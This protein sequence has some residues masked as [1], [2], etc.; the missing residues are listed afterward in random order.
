MKPNPQWRGDPL[1]LPEL[2]RYFGIKFKELPGWKNWGMGDF[3]IIQG[4]FWHHTGANNTPASYIARNTGLGGALSST[5]HTDPI[6]I[7]AI[8]GAGF[9]YHAGRGSG[10]GY[11]TNNAN[12]FSMGFEIQGDGIR[13]WNPAQLESVRRATAVILWFLG[14][15]ATLE[16]MTGH[17][18]YSM[19][20]QGKW[21]PG[22]GNG[23]AGAVMN[24]DHQR[25]LVNQLIDNINKYGQLDPPAAPTEKEGEVLTIKY[26]TDFVKGYIGPAITN[27]Q[28]LVK[29]AEDLQAQLRGPGLKGWAQLGKNAQGQNLTLVDALAALRHDQARIEKKLDE[30][31]GGK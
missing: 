9:A 6:G 16:T 27:I 11:L 30:V 12:P 4:V 3:T 25:K 18:E 2:F 13:A 20:A 31:L 26:F 10:C 5:F 23:R 19:T 22:A 15:R 14:K 24:M 21:D 1:F 17:W 8:C 7:H 28:K 29:L